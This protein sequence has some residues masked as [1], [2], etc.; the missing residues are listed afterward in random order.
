MIVSISDNGPGI[1]EEERAQIFDAF[2]SSKGQGGT[3]LGLAAAS[4]IVSELGGHI[5]VQ[6][7]VGQGTTFH[8]RIPTRQA[9]PADSEKTH[10]PVSGG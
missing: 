4:K 2:H 5:E 10:G 1:P 9:A 8:I 7:V 3:G 6:S